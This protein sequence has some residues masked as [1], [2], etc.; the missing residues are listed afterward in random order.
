MSEQVWAVLLQIAEDDL[1]GGLLLLRLFLPGSDA[2]LEIRRV[3]IDGLLDLLEADQLKGG[4]MLLSGPAVPAGQF[5]IGKP[6]HVT[7][8]A[9][10]GPS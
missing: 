6:K 8:L 9:E 2:P 3:L 7:Q 1:G 10:S 5:R 4:Q